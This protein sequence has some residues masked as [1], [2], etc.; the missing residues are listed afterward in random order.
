MINAFSLLILFVLVLSVAGAILG[1]SA[2]VGRR[3][4]EEACLIPYEC[5][6]DPVGEPRKRFSV[7]F[8]LIATIFIIFEVE[9]V[10]F[11]PLALVFR[12]GVAQGKGL[13]LFGELFLF[14]L[15]LLLGLAYVW[16]SGALD[17]EEK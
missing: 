2:L 15:I 16:R 3:R 8:F 14:T 10:F 5:G 11:Y 17:W 9:I 13:V 1:L 7:Q 6:L 12:E 4:V